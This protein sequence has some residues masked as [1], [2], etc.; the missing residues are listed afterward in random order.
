MVGLQ[1]IVIT[2]ISMKLGSHKKNHNHKC[3]GSGKDLIGKRLNHYFKIIPLKNE[4]I[5]QLWCKVPHMIQTMDPDH[6][7]I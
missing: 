5:N 3:F 1:I 6:R 2:Y 7:W 4:R